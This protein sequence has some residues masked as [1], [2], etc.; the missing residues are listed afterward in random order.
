MKIIDLF[1]NDNVVK[2]SF[3]K[4]RGVEHDTG[5]E[6]PK[7][8]DR[9]ELD[10]K[11]GGNIA[12]II[13]IKGDTRKVVST[14]HLGLMRELVKVYNN[15]GKSDIDI[16]PITMM[17]A[18][19][20]AE[21]NALNDSGIKFYEKPNYWEDFEGNGYAAKY[22]ISE[23]KL[24][25]AEKVLGGIKQYSAKEVYGTDMP[26]SPLVSVQ[27]MPK[28]NVCIIKFGNG[29]RYLVDTTQASTYIRMWAKI[30]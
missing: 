2:G 6:V 22:N 18:F 28:E 29:D 19:G 3:G 10:H 25:K 7:G 1:E 17:Q 24:K 9:F 12:K 13:G 4:K 21:E 26:R 20:S 8:F 16:K 27:S 14:G 30:V 11:D 23:I 15:G 5:I